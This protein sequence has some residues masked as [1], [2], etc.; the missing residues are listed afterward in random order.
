MSKNSNACMEPNGASGLDINGTLVFIGF[1]NQNDIQKA[2]SSNLPGSTILN[3]MST[4]L[5]F[6]I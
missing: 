6:Y 2:R 5:M 4:N 3:L 1:L